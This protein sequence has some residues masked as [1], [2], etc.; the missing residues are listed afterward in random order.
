MGEESA[1]NASRRSSSRGNDPLDATV[2]ELARL[3][4]ERAISPVEVIEGALRRIETFDTA[5]NAFCT[6]D[7]DAAVNAARKAETTVMHGREVGPL[8]GVPVAV[9]DLLFTKGLRTTGGS[10][11][12]RDFVPTLD[13]VSVER[14]RQA[15]AIIVGKTN[16]PT[17]GFGPGTQNP[18]FG[19][20][21]NPWNLDLTPGGSSGGSAAAVAAGLV[22]LALGTDAGGSIRQ[23]ASFCGVIGLKPT[24]GLVPLFPASRDV[25]YPGF[26]A[27]ETLAHVGPLTRDVRDAALCL[28][29][30]AG[31]DRR[32]RHSVPRTASYLDALHSGS[33]TGVNVAAAALDT[34][35]VDSEVA[36]V[37]QATARVLR[38][39]GA[40]VTDI[41]LDLP[42]LAPAY[43]AIV[44]AEADLM[45][46][47][48][49]ETSHPG[50]LNARLKALVRRKWSL[51]EY[52]TAH[53]LR[54][55]A[56]AV[57]SNAFAAFD[58][59]LTPTVPVQPH[60]IGEE[61]GP[62]AAQ[63]T[64]FTMPFNLTGHPAISI[65]NGW[66]TSG[67]PVGTQ[68]VGPRFGEPLLLRAAAALEA[69]SG[70]SATAGIKRT[71]PS[72]LDRTRA[73]K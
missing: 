67:L 24:V 56:Y 29:V 71:M 6:V 45:G 3:I 18:I 42:P 65:P 33:L 61:G 54:A 16:V 70:Q 46:L 58:L 38:S 68:L 32:D 50:A 22:P 31:A 55:T 9:K 34:L 17:F 30:L 36:E 49:L 47:R 39:L 64:R 15:G 23:P 2:I 10:L 19:V 66:T 53:A 72:P 40:E 4:R 43:A 8:H 5:V 41:R 7:A 59:L 28:D 51:E 63:L 11:A 14:I 73:S 37:H 62:V 12:Y 21:R 44:A 60:A 20:T 13:D 48:H 69:A 27:S 35:P 1:R 26:S 52:S 57:V 25:D